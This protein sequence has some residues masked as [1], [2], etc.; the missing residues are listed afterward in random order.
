MPESSR[1]YSARDEPQLNPLLGADWEEEEEEEEGETEAERWAPTS[2]LLLGTS[3]A[4]LILVALCPKAEAKLKTTLQSD[5]EYLT[6]VFGGVWSRIRSMTWGSEAGSTTALHQDSH[7]GK[8]LAPRLPL[9]K[10]SCTKANPYGFKRRRPPVEEPAVPEVFHKYPCRSCCLRITDRAQFPSTS[11]FSLPCNEG[12]PK[13]AKKRMPEREMPSRKEAGQT[14][15]TAPGAR[16]IRRKR[17][18]SLCCPWDHSPGHIGPSSV[19]SWCQPGVANSLAGALHVLRAAKSK[20][21]QRLQYLR[22][23]RCCCSHAS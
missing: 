9:R 14:S 22:N 7:C 4:L 5:W 20:V 21:W 11:S 15:P 2:Y 13:T 17:C 3:L 16:R 18:P 12:S 10:A 23:R 8:L 19:G 1:K 6:G